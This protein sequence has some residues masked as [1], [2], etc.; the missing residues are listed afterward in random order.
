MDIEKARFNMVEQQIRP[1][2]V[3]D[4]GVLNLLF[5]VKREEFV[6][7]AYQGL[8]FVDM[9]IPLGHGEV[10]LSPKLEARIL[11]EVAVKKTDKV[12]E[13]GTGS[14]YMTALLAHEAMHVYSVEIIPEFKMQADQNL[15]AHGIT[16]AT[17]EIG[18]AACDWNRQGPYD[19]IILTGSVPVIPE[20]FK[21]NLTTGGRLFV[22]EGDA[23]L[24]EAKLIT[25][26]AD[27]VYN[28]VVLFETCIAPLKNVLQPQ[29]FVF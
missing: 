2:D 28:T 15:K 20:K 4:Q 23:P 8:T 18:D 29:R 11:Q 27:G 7:L 6:P 5:K 10:M 19:V 25:C 9:E 21:Q 17:L 1:W 26:V 24:M 3:L 16:N 12:L 14:G 13:V 22:V